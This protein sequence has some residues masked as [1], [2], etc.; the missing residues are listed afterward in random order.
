MQ[1]NLGFNFAGMFQE[2]HWHGQTGSFVRFHCDAGLGGKEV[3]EK[4]ARIT[5]SQN[6]RGWK[7][8]LE[9]IES[10]LLLK[11]VPYSRLH[12]QASREDVFW[13][14]EDQSS[15]LLIHQMVPMAHQRKGTLTTWPQNPLSSAP[16]EPQRFAVVLDDWICRS[17][18]FG[19]AASPL[20]SLQAC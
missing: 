11:Q 20:S 3:K 10:N 13:V 19:K 6:C 2:C 5:E 9:I 7:G 14:V 15:F 18:Q 17:I 8:P 12:R 4:K 1:Q 16:I